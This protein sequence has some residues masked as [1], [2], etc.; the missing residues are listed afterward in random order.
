MNTL[1][2]TMLNISN[3]ASMNNTENVNLIQLN[4][5]MIAGINY[6]N[7]SKRL[8]TKYPLSIQIKKSGELFIDGPDENISNNKNK[9][10][11]YSDK[12]VTEK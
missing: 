6:L 3:Q 9:I 5:I 7:N 8:T 10:C 12:K 11:I 2:K 1:L 4:T